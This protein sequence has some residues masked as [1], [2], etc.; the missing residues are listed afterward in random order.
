MLTVICLMIF[1]SGFVS[2][3]RQKGHQ[4]WM[5]VCVGFDD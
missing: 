3:G 1:F 4:A 2:F 5:L